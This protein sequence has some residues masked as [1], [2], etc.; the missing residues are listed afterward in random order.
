MKQKKEKPLKQIIEFFKKDQRFKILQNSPINFRD[1]V[2][3]YHETKLESDNLKIH[4]EAY[5]LGGTT[6][7]EKMHVINKNTNDFTNYDNSRPLSVQDL[8]KKISKN[9]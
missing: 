5:I 1:G 3:Y 2:E 8:I 9:A 6:S 7:N 4:Y